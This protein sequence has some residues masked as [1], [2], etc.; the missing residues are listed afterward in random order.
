MREGGGQRAGSDEGFAE[1]GVVVVGGD[2]AVGRDILR[3]VAI[4]IIRWEENA[5]VADHREEA[6]DAAG[7][8]E[9]T[10]DI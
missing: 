6:A 8:L 1:G 10:V 4:R 9:R 3:D 2:S 7:A 5:V